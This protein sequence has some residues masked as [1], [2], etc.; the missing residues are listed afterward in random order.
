MAVSW[1]MMFRK[2]HGIIIESEICKSIFKA[3]HQPSQQILCVKSLSLLSSSSINEAYLL[4]SI[5]STDDNSNIHPNILS[6]LSIKYLPTLTIN[7]S[8]YFIFDYAYNRDLATHGLLYGGTEKQ[9][10][11]EQIQTYLYQLLSAIN[12]CHDRLVYHCA[13]ELKHLL[14]T[15][16]GQLKLSNFEYAKHAVLPTMRIN[17]SDVSCFSQSPPE[18]LLGDRTL[19]SS[20][21]MWSAGCVFAQLCSSTQ[22][23][24]L[25][26]G[27]HQIELLF[28]IFSMMGTPTN[29]IW[30]LFH[31]LSYFNVDFPRWPRRNDHLYELTKLIGAQGLDFL[32]CL[33]TYDPK[34]RTTARIALQH[35][36]FKH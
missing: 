31:K 35:Q 26:H 3:I 16:T 6:L 24:P 11:N 10:T 20:L 4:R 22:I 23:Q 2:H 33:L 30:P 15:R 9:L 34:Q 19:N 13:I 36:Y 17:I 14:I 21:D 12:F 7:N 29:D 18:L 8:I 25:F 1:T 32:K 28:C 27:N 5:L